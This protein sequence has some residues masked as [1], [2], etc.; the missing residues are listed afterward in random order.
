MRFEGKTIFVTGGAGFIGSA[1]VRH[2]LERHRRERRQYRQAHLR[3]EPRLDPAGRGASALRLRQGRHLQ[4]RRPSRAVRSTPAR[5]RDEPRGRKPCRSL[6]RR[7]RRIHPDQHR[8]H[9]HAAAGGAA[10]LAQP[11]AGPARRASASCTSRPTRSTARSAT[12]GPVHRETRP[13]RRTRPIPRARR[14]PIIWC[15]PGAR[16]MVFRPW[17]PTAP[18]ITGPIISRK[19]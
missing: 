3:R 2:L 11:R 14:R 17:S 15:A 4:R 5:F 8:R 10:L 16:P 1:V 9:L 19:S 18:T 12:G 7:P 13:T 6:D